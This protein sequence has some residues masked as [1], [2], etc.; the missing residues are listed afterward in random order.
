[1]IWGVAPARR[2]FQAMIAE[3]GIYAQGASDAIFAP[4]FRS[5]AYIYSRVE[6]NFHSNQSKVNVV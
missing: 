2:L 6:I 1:M 4:V 5:L 3:A